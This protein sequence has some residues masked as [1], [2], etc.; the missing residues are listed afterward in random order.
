MRED[1]DWTY[2]TNL[3]TSSTYDVSDKLAALMEQQLEKPTDS[4]DLDVEK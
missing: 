2:A 3:A 4:K 1:F